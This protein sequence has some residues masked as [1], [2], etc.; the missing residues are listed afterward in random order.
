MNKRVEH[1]LRIIKLIS[2]RKMRMVIGN[3]NISWRTFIPLLE[4]GH[5]SKFREKKQN[6]KICIMKNDIKK[7]FFKTN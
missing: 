3:L 4:T 7:N 2:I 6:T 5:F 1:L